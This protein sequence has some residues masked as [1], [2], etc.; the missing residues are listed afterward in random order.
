MQKP[1]SLTQRSSKMRGILENMAQNFIHKF[2]VVK[3]KSFRY[4][5]NATAVS[6]KSAK[7]KKTQS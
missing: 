7:I 1:M 4:K 6:H 5:K 2:S 3:S